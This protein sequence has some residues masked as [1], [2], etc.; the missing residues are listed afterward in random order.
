MR[1]R[2]ALRNA[3]HQQDD[4]RQ[5]QFRHAARIRK[6]R[7]EHRD[8]VLLRRLEIHLIG[9]DAEAPHRD[10]PRRAASNTAAVNCVDERM[11]TT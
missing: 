6:R 9:A 4:F 7:V 1:R 10:Q 11:P 2:V 8:A 5:H 3:A